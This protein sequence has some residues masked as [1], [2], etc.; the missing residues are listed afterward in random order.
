MEIDAQSLRRVLG[1][2]FKFSKKD[3]LVQGSPTGFM[4]SL[5]SRSTGAGIGATLSWR[6]D[7]ILGNG[8]ATSPTTPPAG[9]P[10]PDLAAAQASA[11]SACN[12]AFNTAFTA[13]I[14]TLGTFADSD[15]P[16][17]QTSSN[18][19]SNAF[20][21][22][23]GSYA[24]ATNENKLAMRLVCKSSVLPISLRLTYTIEEWHA[25]TYCIDISNCDLPVNS[26]TV[27]STGTLDI[28]LTALDTSGVY[29]LLPDPP[30]IVAQAWLPVSFP[31]PV[32]AHTPVQITN[33]YY[34]Y[35][36]TNIARI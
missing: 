33:L 28:I 22:S 1:D 6:R 12:S 14:W 3:F 31:A 34:R 13:G 21:G 10:A 27:S 35:N 36:F 9:N 19:A 29:V 4:V 11:D 30:N 32:V 5:N 17:V 18:K 16:A 23:S 2:M 26:M 24:S 8:S 20:R 7:I 25:E 15:L